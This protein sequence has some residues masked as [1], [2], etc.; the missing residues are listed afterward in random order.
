M[1]YLDSSKQKNLRMCL[2]GAIEAC[3]AQFLTE[4]WYQK[5]LQ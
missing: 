2:Y 1:L 4:F 5:E 3:T